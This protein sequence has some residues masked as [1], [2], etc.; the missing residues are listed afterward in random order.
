MLKVGDVVVTKSP[1]WHHGVD[2][3][4]ML[5]VVISVKSHVIIEIAGFNDNPVKCFQHEL[6][7]VEREE[8]A[9]NWEEVDTTEIDM[10]DF[11]PKI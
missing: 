1:L 7:K 6:E 8:D 11:F 2:V 5:G 3:G 4:N 10:S 9:G